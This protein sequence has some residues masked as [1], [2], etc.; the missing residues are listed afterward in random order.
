MPVSTALVRAEITRFLE[1]KDKIALCLNGKWG[2]GKTHAWDAL[3]KDAFQRKTAHPARY[4]Y[5]S[6]FGLE[7]LADVRR[8]IFENTQE[9][10]AFADNKPFEA[11]PEHVA[12]RISNM[13]S[14]WRSGFGLL[15]GLPLVSDYAGIAEKLGFLSVR[16]QIVCFDDLE[17]I[18]ESLNVKDV[19]GLVSL[20]KEQRGCK[21]VLLLNSDA[22][23]DDNSREFEL[24]LEK[25]IDVHLRYEPTAEESA[26]V[27]VPAGS[28]AGASWVAENAVRLGIANI[29][30][31]M[32]LVRIAQRLEEVLGTYDERIR[33]QAIHSACLFGFAIH[34]PNDA[35]PLAAILQPRSL[36]HL[37]G[38]EDKRTPEQIQWSEL[39]SAYRFSSAD[40]LDRVVCESVQKGVFDANA[41]RA[42]ADKLASQLHLSDQRQQY[43]GVWDIYHDSFD[44]DAHQFTR[45]LRRSIN[46]QALVITK[47]DLSASITMLKD[48]GDND[49]LN[50]LISAYVRTRQ[51][52]KE[53]WQNDPDE[54]R[55]EKYDPDVAAAFDAKLAKFGEDRKLE[56]ILASIVSKNGWNRSDLAFI[57]THSADDFYTMLKAA[58]GDNLR[59]IASGLLYFQQISNA[60][61]TMVSITEKA[62]T[63]L[64]RIGDESDLN[65][66]RVRVFGVEIESDPSDIQ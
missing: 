54:P 15:K 58:R 66:R 46:D 2:V 27:A 41:L 31:I 48:L 62:L 39:M 52:G 19:L 57:D 18:S 23:D 3:V 59:Q 32:K 37:F 49:G 40:D 6:L 12:D 55:Y 61:A 38:G 28:P 44:D 42:E 8:S 51:E 63:A 45:A 20:L 60:D 25:V 14:K 9:A 7:S 29:R 30:T 36:A 50:D 5:V 21:V 4:S 34:Q 47:S 65:R 43:R 16:N 26:V 17:R 24:Q 33:K 64:R 11:T 56:D 35:P 53:F 10:K 13:T 1:T 22:M